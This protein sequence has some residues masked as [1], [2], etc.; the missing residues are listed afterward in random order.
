MAPPPIEDQSPLQFF[1]TPHTDAE[2]VGPLFNQRACI[3]CHGHSANN[4]G[5][6]TGGDSGDTPLAAV[7][8]VNTPVSRG[9]R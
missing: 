4:H 3:G 6:L 2:G 1:A 9:G 7:N 8:A 5:N